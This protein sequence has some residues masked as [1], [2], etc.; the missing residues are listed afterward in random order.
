MSL[1]NLRPMVFN[2]SG[3][4][5]GAFAD[6]PYI[7]LDRL[8]PMHLIIDDKGKVMH[9]GP[10]LA[11]IA[12]VDLEGMSF[13]ELIKVL[14]PRGV[15]DL[16][17]MRAADGTQLRV[18]LQGNEDLM[19]KGICVPLADA[20]AL[21]NLSFGYA[22]TTAVEHFHLACGDLANTDLTIEMLYLIEAKSA[23]Q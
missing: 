4:Q 17:A 6:L 23:A 8:M 2:R 1:S 13:N 7:A 21:I 15:Q 3:E 18:S 10:T 9:V 5:Q 12:P 16:A 20:G 19:L 14:Q 11:K 22:V